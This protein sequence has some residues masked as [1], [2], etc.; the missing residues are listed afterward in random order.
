MAKKLTKKQKE[1]A[2]DFKETGNA[3]Q[4]AK[5]VY[6]PKNDNTAGAIGSENLSKPKIQQYLENTAEEAVVRIEVL[7]KKA[8]NE[9]VRLNANKDLA[10][11]G[12]LKPVDKQDITSK[13]ERIEGINYIVPEK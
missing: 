3:T 6:N 13:G 4:S 2:D 1:F 12:G 11:R 7:S 9:T 10:D 5:K 8:K